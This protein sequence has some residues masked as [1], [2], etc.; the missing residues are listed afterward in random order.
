VHLFDI[1]IPDKMTFK[2]S[3]TL[4]PHAPAAPVIQLLPCRK[5]HLFDI[6]IPGKMTFKES[7]TLTPGEMPTVVDTAAGRLG[8]GICYDIRFPELAMLYAK[9]GVQVLVYPG[10]A[11]VV[12]WL[13]YPRCC[14]L[15]I[16]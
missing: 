3:L 7:L 16:V 11:A 14:S 13:A 1:D 6:D 2:E 12:R 8:L 4:T 10:A 9:R 15:C 5:V